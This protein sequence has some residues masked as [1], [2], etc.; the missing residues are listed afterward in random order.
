MNFNKLPINNNFPEE[1][2]VIIEISYNSN[3]VKYEINKNNNLI[4]VDRFIPCPIFYPC[5]Y[6][7]INNTLSLDG[8]PIDALVI[9]PYSLNIGTVILCRPIGLL[10]TTDESGQDIKLIMLPSNKICNEYNYINDIDDISKSLKLK[11]TYFFENYKKLESKK[12]TEVN[13]W[14]N[15]ETAKKEMLMALDRAKQKK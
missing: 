11:I 1:T 12:W 8:D 9:T 10:K 3:P 15:K 6:G 2:Y 13:G 4:F 14:A 5:N 7:Y